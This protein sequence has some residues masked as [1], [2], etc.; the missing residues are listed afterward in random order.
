MKDEFEM[1]D[2]GLMRY[3]M[4]IEVHQSKTSIF[5]SQSKYAHEILKRFNMVNSKVAPTPVII[6]LKLS[7]E[8]KGSKVDS[9]LFKILVGSLM[10]L[11]TTRLDIMYGVSLISRF[12]ENP[13]ELNWKEGKRILRYVNE[14]KY[15]GIKYSTSE[16]FK[17]IG[18]TDNDCGGSID[19]RKSTS[20]YTFHYGIGMV[21]WASR[22]HPIVTLSSAEVEYVA[23]TS[24]TCQA[25]WMRIILKDLLQEQQ[26]PTT[27]LC[28]NNSAILLSKNHVFHKKTNHIDTRYHFIRELVNNKE[29]CLEFCKSKEQIADIFTKVLARDAFQ[30]LRNN[31]GV[32]TI[33]DE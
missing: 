31:L 1:T 30:H 23:A 25:V 7:K 13:K 9:T 17:L 5:I 19:D 11:T 24:S 4:G 15:F 14:T 10:Y 18:Y 21:S 6:G 33:T 12:M 22:K 29:I 20:R 28:D 8:D 3:F 16:D 26:E 32:H 27:V 2:L